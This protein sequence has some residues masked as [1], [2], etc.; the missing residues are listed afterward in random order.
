MKSRYSIIQMSMAVVTLF[1][2]S[3]KNEK[4]N[5]VPQVNNNP[6]PQP[7]Y[8]SVNDMFK[9]MEVKA[10][11]VTIDASKA[12]SFYGNSGTRY[13]L[14][15]NSLEKMDGTAVTGNVD[16]TVREFLT[17]GDMIFSKMLPVSN[18][19]PLISGGE[20]DIKAS[21]NGQPLR[22]KDNMVFTANIPQAH[23]A[24]PAMQFFMGEPVEGKQNN[25]NWQ[26]PNGQGGQGK[27]N[28]VIVLAGDTLSLF[29]DSMMM[30]NADR[31]MTNPDY[32]AFTVNVNVTGAAIVNDEDV[33]GYAV[34]DNA[35]G[36]WP[37][38]Q[39]AGGKINENHVPGIPVHFVVFALI[40]GEFYGGTAAATPDDGGVYSVTLAKTDAATFK[41]QINDL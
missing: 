36:M 3:C 6:K 34:Y 14:P 31:F 2:F 5:V 29:S 26:R 17:K 15:A 9:Q 27:G 10:K 8:S 7:T 39:Y 30:C 38:I 18:G 23:G 12:E 13:I 28:G 41:Q 40:D 1:M 4:D 35:L 20:L 33:Y 21:Q 32:K 19:M 22:L 16:V 37:M 25:V 11:T 24:D